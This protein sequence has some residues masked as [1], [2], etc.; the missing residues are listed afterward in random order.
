MLSFRPAKEYYM[1]EVLE[2]KEPGNHFVSRDWG[3]LTTIPDSRWTLGLQER[4]HP[5][6]HSPTYDEPMDL[7]GPGDN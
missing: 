4:E 5:G 1:L 6:L 2:G 3:L 7:S